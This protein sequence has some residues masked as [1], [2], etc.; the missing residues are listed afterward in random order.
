MPENASQV[1]R[2]IAIEEH[3]WN[4]DL[5]AALLKFGGDDTLAWSNEDTTNRRLLDV[6]EERLARMDEAGVD[7]QVLSITAPGTQQL[8][9]ELAVSLARDANDYLAD[10][11]RRR[12]DRF[13]AFATLPTP[14]PEAAAAELRRCVTD[15]NFVGAMLFPRTGPNYLD[16]SS[17]RPIFAAAAELKVPLYI[18]PGVPLEA[19]RE[20]CYGG[21]GFVTNLMLSTG[22][23]GWHAEAGLAALRL[24]LAGTFDRHP[25]LQL[26]LGHMGEMLVSFADRADAL[27]KTTQL[28]R[29][30][31]DYITGN[32]YA[33]PGGVF[34]HRMLRQILDVLGPDR[35]M[36]A[37]D[38][39]FNSTLGKQGKNPGG[40]QSSRGFARDFIETA[41]I[42]AEEKSKL[43]HLNAERLLLAKRK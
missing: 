25:E 13:A 43:A 28:E 17:F 24:I 41:P 36:F 1:S 4:P 33:T 34:S 27:T 14:D 30:I 20:A 12:P 29:S 39:P 40:P 5:R 3:A 26:I 10:A 18:H 32:I 19:V 42:S 37:V 9:P 6:G 22:G 16:H 11:V 31:L 15:L 38:D 7:F 8:P 2:V 35:I 23:W 21:F